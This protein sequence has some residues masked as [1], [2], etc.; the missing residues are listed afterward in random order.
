MSSTESSTKESGVDVAAGNTWY[1]G[2]AKGPKTTSGYPSGSWRTAKHWTDGWLT[3]NTAPE[4]F[5]RYKNSK[6]GRV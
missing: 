5:E 4:N 6:G 1:D 2:V 3:K